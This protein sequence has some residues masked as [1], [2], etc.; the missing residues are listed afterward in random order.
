MQ[1]YTLRD[2]HAAKQADLLRAKHQMTDYERRLHDFEA[3]LALEK[4]DTQVRLPLWLWVSMCLICACASAGCVLLC[5]DVSAR[6]VRV[7][8]SA[9]L[10]NRLTDGQADR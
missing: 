6:G 3:A 10:T 9:F 5:K 4:R 7:C 8:V 1:I 2:E